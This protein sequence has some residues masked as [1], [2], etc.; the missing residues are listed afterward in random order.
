[1]D[2]KLLLNYDWPNTKGWV[3]QPAHNFYRG[4][5]ASPKVPLFNSK[6]IPQD[7]WP[8]GWDDLKDPKWEGES[9]RQ[10]FRNGYSLIH[11]IYVAQNDQELNWERSLATGGTLR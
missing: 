4:I 7:Q 2:A 10:F 11:G 5:V 6:V 1:M 9:A 8:K 3:N